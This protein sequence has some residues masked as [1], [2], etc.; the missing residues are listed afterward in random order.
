MNYSSKKAENESQGSRTV[1]RNKC[2]AEHKSRSQML[3][4]EPISNTVARRWSDTDKRVL[5]LDD[6][7]QRG[8]TLLAYWP[9]G[10]VWLLEDLE[11]LFTEQR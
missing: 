6:E 11:K 7:G 3:P 1:G 8:Q 9:H 5:F 4:A 10:A 2:V